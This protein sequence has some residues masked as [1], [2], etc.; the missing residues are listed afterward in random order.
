MKKTYIHPTMKV[1]TLGVRSTMLTGS[2]FETV[3]IDENED[4]AAEFK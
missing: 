2:P 1:V 3:R 4:G